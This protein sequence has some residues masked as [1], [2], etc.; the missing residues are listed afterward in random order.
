VDIC[1]AVGGAGG[2]CTRQGCNAGECESPY[3][4]CG[5]CAENVASRLPFD[6]SA[7]LPADFVEPLTAAPASCICE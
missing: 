7:C 2:F 1:L 6:G 5:G 3:V 4:C